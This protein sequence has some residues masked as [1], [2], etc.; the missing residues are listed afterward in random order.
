[1]FHGVSLA[2]GLGRSLSRPRRF[3]AVHFARRTVGSIMYLG[4]V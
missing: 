4:A 3:G 2:P 1:M